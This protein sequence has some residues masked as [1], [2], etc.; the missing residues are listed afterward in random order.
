MTIYPNEIDAQMIN[1]DVNFGY[2]LHCKGNEMYKPDEF[3]QRIWDM[4]AKTS[5]CTNARC[6]EFIVGIAIKSAKS[7]PDL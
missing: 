6:V 1:D 5:I 4:I 2:S 3:A 7:V